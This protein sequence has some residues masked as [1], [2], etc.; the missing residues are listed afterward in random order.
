MCK[1]TLC[2]AVPLSA[3]IIIAGALS[4]SGG[5]LDPALP[6]APTM[7]TLEDIYTL[8]SDNSH[9]KP[10]NIRNIHAVIDTGVVTGSEIVVPFTTS[11]HA[12]IN[13]L[14]H[15]GELDNGFVMRSD[16]S[17]TTPGVCTPLPGLFRDQGQATFSV[18]AAPDGIKILP[19]EDW[20]FGL[21]HDNPNQDCGTVHVTFSGYVY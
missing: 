7:H 11:Y 10:E 18:G 5:N 12:F 19:G 13:V 2:L 21:R 20:S 9:P 4:A 17:I 14:D 3:A 8:V 6:P 15:V 16:V 1:Q